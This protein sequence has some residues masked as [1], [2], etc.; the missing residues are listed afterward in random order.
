MFA[1]SLTLAFHIDFRGELFQFVYLH[2]IKKKF[3]GLHGFEYNMHNKH[4]D[5]KQQQ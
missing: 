1:K 3:S 4:S 2:C 5:P